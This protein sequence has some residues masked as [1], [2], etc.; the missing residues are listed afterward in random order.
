M[1][2]GTSE[3]KVG[4][5]LPSDAEFPPNT[6]PGVARSPKDLMAA[7]TNLMNLTQ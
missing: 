6:I 3:Y 7:I 5:V 1:S 4:N 2:Y